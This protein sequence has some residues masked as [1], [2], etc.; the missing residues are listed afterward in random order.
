MCER[1][2]ALKQQ[3][4]EEGLGEEF[5]NMTKLTSSGTTIVGSIFQGGVVMGGDSRATQGNLIA[6]KK[7]MKVLCLTDKIYVCGAGGSA[8]ITKVA[9]ITSAELKLFELNSGLQARVAMAARRLR[10]YLFKHMGYVRCY[11]LVGGVDVTGSHIYSVSASGAG[12]RKAFDADGSGCYCAIAEMEAMFKPN[13]TEEECIALVKKGLEGG[14]RG[15]NMSGNSYNLTIGTADG[16]RCEGPFKPS[17]VKAEKAENKFMF[18][19][20][21]ITVLSKCVSMQKI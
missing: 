9:Q 7:C 12:I 21:S 10:Q 18:G 19:P 1:N 14:M 16:F 5:N 13:M 6:D 4:D 17:F 8:D 20:E 15:D 2:L 3:M 11:Y